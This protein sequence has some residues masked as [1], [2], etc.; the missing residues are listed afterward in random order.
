MKLD[1]T[2]LEAQTLL[3]NASPAWRNQRV[4]NNRAAAPDRK[5]SALRIGVIAASRRSSRCEE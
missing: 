5:N 2:R 4:S 3:P 1:N